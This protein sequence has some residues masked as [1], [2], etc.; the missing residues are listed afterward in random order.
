[1][2]PERPPLDAAA[3]QRRR[4]IKH[5]AAA[6]GILWVTPLMD[7]IVSVAAAASVP[8]TATASLWKSGN[9]SANPP[10]G[11]LCST[12]ATSTAGRGTAVFTRNDTLGTIC[13]TVTLSTGA[14][15]QS[16]SIFILQ[17]TAGGTCVG[18]TT[19]PVGFWAASPAAGPQTF[20]APIASGATAFVIAQQLTG[21]GGNDGWASAPP[22][23]L[24]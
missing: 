18:G 24:P 4:L 22:V 23:S 10:L 5:A 15:A 21:G 2:D 12:G 6:G 14:D 20:C 17:S 3:R 7:S 19:T 1:M 8:T 13:V 11:N 16:R 9:G